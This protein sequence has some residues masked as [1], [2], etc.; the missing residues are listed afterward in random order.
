MKRVKSGIEG[1]DQLCEGGLP[2]GSVTL[3]SGPAGSAKSLFG[4][5]FI[6]SGAK[7]YGEPGILILVEEPRRNLYRT[8]KRYNFEIEKLEAEGKILV[9]DLGEIRALDELVNFESLR[10][11]IANSARENNATRIVVDSLS[12]IGVAYSGEDL[13]RKEM[14]KFVRFLTESGFTSILISEAPEGKLTKYDFEKFLVDGLIM[15]NYENVKGEYRRTL[16]IYKMRFTRHDPYKHP[17]IIS[18]TGIEIE[19]DEVIF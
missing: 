16:T 12:G 1:F 17:F 5:E 19:P 6:Y 13:L 4:L 10:S 11:Y 15:L 18:K 14:F 9:L 2:E 7:K 3:V 8:A